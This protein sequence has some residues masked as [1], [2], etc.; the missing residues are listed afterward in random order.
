MIRIITKLASRW[1]AYN[2]Y[3]MMLGGIIFP[4]KYVGD[5]A[6]PMFESSQ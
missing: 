4:R 2:G 5:V 6:M 3:I 1:I